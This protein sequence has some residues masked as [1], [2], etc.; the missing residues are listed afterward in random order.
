MRIRGQIPLDNPKT[1]LRKLVSTSKFVRT[2]LKFSTRP[3]T[4]ARRVCFG[5]NRGTDHLRLLT[6]SQ[7]GLLLQS[8]QIESNSQQG[9]DM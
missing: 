6:K 9:I 8:M 3:D 1:I 4:F 7:Q 5:G 2:L